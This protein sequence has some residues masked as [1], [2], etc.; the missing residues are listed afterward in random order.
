M[1]MKLKGLTGRA[2]PDTNVSGCADRQAAV[3]GKDTDIDY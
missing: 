2:H 1:K 3:P